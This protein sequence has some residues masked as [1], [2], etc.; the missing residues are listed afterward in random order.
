MLIQYVKPGN[1]LN[2]FGKSKK[3]KAKEKKSMDFL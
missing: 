1:N 2:L 3:K